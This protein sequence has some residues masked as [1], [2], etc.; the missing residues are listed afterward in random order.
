MKTQKFISILS[1]SILTLLSLLLSTYAACLTSPSSISVSSGSI[2]F[3]DINPSQK[4]FVKRNLEQDPL[5]FQ[6]TYE[7]TDP[8]CFS[9]NT[10]MSMQLFPFGATSIA[11]SL[12]TSQENGIESST[13]IFNFQLEQNITNPFTS[14]FSGA[15]SDGESISGTLSLATENT[16]PEF[17]LFSVQ[18][19]IQTIKKG[20]EISIDFIVQDTESL[21]SQITIT[22]TGIETTSFEDGQ[23]TFE[24]SILETL[25]S[26]QSFFIRARDRLGL[27]TTQQVNFIIDG[28]G[29]QIRDIQGVV[30]QNSNQKFLKL[31]AKIEDSSFS[32]AG[33][34]GSLSADFSSLGSNI[35]VRDASCF[36]ASETIL[37]CEFNPIPISLA[38]SQV[39]NIPLTATD[40]LGNE[41]STTHPFDLLVDTNSAEILEFKL[42]NSQGIENLL[43]PSDSGSFI[44]LVFKDESIGQAQSPVI[45]ENFGTLPFVTRECSSSGTTIT[46]TWQLGNSVQVYANNPLDEIY[47]V[48]VRDAFS[49]EIEE[50]F[51]VSVDNQGPVVDRVEIIETESIKDGIFKSGERVNFQVFFEDNNFFPEGRALGDF[52]ELDFRA[53]L[54]AKLGT[55]SQFSTEL[56]RCDFNNIIFENGH[57]VRDVTFTLI[58]S[59][60]NSVEEVQEVEVLRISD[61]VVSSFR[62]QE[63]DITNPIN[64]K[65]LLSTSADAW[66]E[67]RIEKID[68]EM[69]IIN[70]QLT[71]CTE[72]DLDPLLLLRFGLFPEDIVINTEDED[73]NDFVVKVEMKDH[74]N[75]LDMNDKSMTCTISILKRDSENVFPAELVDVQ[76]NFE[77]FDIPRSNLIKAQAESILVD[78]EATEYL[79]GYFA[80]IYDI[81]AIFSNVCGLLNGGVGVLSSASNVITGV[82]YMM[83]GFPATKA[84]ASAAGVA[85]YGTE[86]KLSELVH[87]EDIKKI[88]SYATCENGGFIGSITDGVLPEGTLD[89]PIFK[90]LLDVQNTIGEAMC[91]GNILSE[92]VNAVSSTAGAN[93]P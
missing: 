42:V 36:E 89:N 58:D 52:S 24:G 63:I 65:V 76:L 44:R 30:F 28:T 81:Y 43:S 74:P 15:T 85:T 50:S 41:L 45:I 7:N 4:I 79:G 86:S 78:I 1:F 35:G 18:P 3:D 49:N 68:D 20:E 88:C 12:V 29:P 87:F 10:D 53:G 31:E 55:C 91:T 5:Q 62:I 57:F 51:T 84:A 9:A 80:D 6:F 14:R 69:E 82:Q 72:N 2:S 19:N 54:D 37:Q 38:E 16:P 21:L 75:I 60:G 73:V 13:F 67:G 47:S 25:E 92:G 61:E 93:E 48:R 66:F 8:S 64:R 77:F 17:L 59:S 32:E 11:D 56:I 26:S 71:G 40:A 39:V 23:L 70:Y 27:E 33:A 46:C 34:Q 22:G 83:A 90:T